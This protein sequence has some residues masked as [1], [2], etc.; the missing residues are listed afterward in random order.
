MKKQIISIVYVLSGL[1][2]AAP[3]AL[4]FQGDLTNASIRQ[5][6][7]SMTIRMEGALRCEMP[8]SGTATACFPM[9]SDS[10]SGREYALTPAGDSLRLYAEG[11]R[12]VRVEG[13]ISAGSLALTSIQPL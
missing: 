10:K 9:F 1:A 2:A 7:R 8:S 6:L 3:V 5:E 13:K 12:S 11:V 4:A